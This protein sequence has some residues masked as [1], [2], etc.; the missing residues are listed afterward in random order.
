MV[1]FKSPSEKPI[2]R[3]DE[4]FPPSRVLPA[5]IETTHTTHSDRPYIFPQDRDMRY[6]LSTEYYSILFN[7]YCRSMCYDIERPSLKQ[8]ICQMRPSPRSFYC[9]FS[10]VSS[11]YRHRKKLCKSWRSSFPTASIP[12]TS[13]SSGINGPPSHRPHSPTRTAVLTTFVK[14]C[15]QDSSVLRW[16]IFLRA[17]EFQRCSIFIS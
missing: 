5:L 2:F 16:C 7:L 8:Q 14:P 15:E 11:S 4:K 1:Q 13:E 17:Q 9:S 12:N 6:Y 3:A 10:C